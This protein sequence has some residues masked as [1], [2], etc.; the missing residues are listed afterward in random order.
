MGTGNKG[1]ENKG[2]AMRIKIEAFRDGW[3]KPAT[4]VRVVR[5]DGNFEI[6]QDYEGRTC[7]VAQHSGMTEKNKAYIAAGGAIRTSS[8]RYS[9]PKAGD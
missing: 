6:G 7:R 4:D 3:D 8:N 5:F 1:K 2:N 9:K